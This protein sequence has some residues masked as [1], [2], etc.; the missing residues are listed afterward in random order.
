[1][2]GEGEREDRKVSKC[3]KGVTEDWNV[4]VKII[5]LV[6]GSFG[7]ILK[8]FGN[9]LKETGITAEIGQVQKTVFLGTAGIFRKVLE[10]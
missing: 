5:P 10:I 2:I 8:K 3:K 4:R 6:V 9:S 7:A 1:M